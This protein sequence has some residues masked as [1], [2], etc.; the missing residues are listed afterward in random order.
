MAG[1]EQKSR[2]FTRFFG[3]SKPVVEKKAEVSPE[4]LVR[5]LELCNKH[6]FVEVNFVDRQQMS[7]QSLIIHVDIHNDSLLIDELYPL[8]PS[9]DIVAG[10]SIE[11]TSRGKGLPVKFTS[12]ISAL[13]IYEGAPA[14][15]V[16]LPKTV[17]ANQRREFFRVPVNND[18]GI[19]L[20]IPLADG[21]QGFCTVLNISSTG[22]CFRFDKNITDQIRAG[23]SIKN[24]KL[25]LPGNTVMNCDLEVRSYDYKKSPERFTL[26]GAS[27]GGFAPVEQKKF[28]RYLVRLQRAMKRGDE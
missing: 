2:F 5:L 24:A 12:T 17:K 26:V 14:Y 21:G 7:Y 28:D 15:R 8:E 10:E 1:S 27:F 20:H 19:H 22:I 25:T 18:M 6:T 9:F 13:E 4:T 23:G 11:I 3:G 16:A